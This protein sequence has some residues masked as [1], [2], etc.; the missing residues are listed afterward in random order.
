MASRLNLT[1]RTVKFHVSSLL[2]KFH[3]KRRV[4]LFL[5]SDIAWVRAAQPAKS[6]PHWPVQKQGGMAPALPLLMPTARGTT[7]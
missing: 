2:R 1:E 4:G 5:H 3:V 6:E 7:A